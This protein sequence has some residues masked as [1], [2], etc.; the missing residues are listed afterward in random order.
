MHELCLLFP[1]L[2]ALSQ[3]G[4]T[5]L[6]HPLSLLFVPFR[7]RE[8]KKD[9]HTQHLKSQDLV[10]NMMS[11]D[12]ISNRPEVRQ[13]THLCAPDYAWVRAD[14]LKAGIQPPLCGK[15]CTTHCDTLRMSGVSHTS[16]RG[17][18]ELTTQAGL[19]DLRSVNIS[20]GLAVRHDDKEHSE[21]SPRPHA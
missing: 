14:T 2:P 10:A 6:V 1:F 9:P 20:K 15:M 19:K 16:R 8:H 4:I 21:R 3:K 12:M 5:A 18:Q 17:Q 13:C 11:F 7:F